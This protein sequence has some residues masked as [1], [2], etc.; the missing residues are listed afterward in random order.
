MAQPGAAD[1]SLVAGDAPMGSLEGT[2][3]RVG[4]A[5]STLPCCMYCTYA[6]RAF[7]RFGTQLYTVRSVYSAATVYIDY[8]GVSG[9]VVVDVQDQLSVAHFVAPALG[10]IS[11]ESVRCTV[12][13]L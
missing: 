11:Q 12:L 9:H 1:C 2:R 8:G 3:V 7:S 13:R 6:S 4:S 10:H 5:Y